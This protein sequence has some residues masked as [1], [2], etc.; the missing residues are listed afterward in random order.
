MRY[1]GAATFLVHINRLNRMTD[2]SPFRLGNATTLLAGKA[3]LFDSLQRALHSTNSIQT[4]QTGPSPLFIKEEAQQWLYCETSG[5]TGAAKTIKRSP[6]S[7]IRSFAENGDLF[8]LSDKDRYATLGHI[9]HS[10]TLYAL[11]E[12]FHHGADIAMMDSSSPKAQLLSLFEHQISILYATPTQLRLLAHAARAKNQA[13]F[14]AL[15]LLMI[16][17]GKLDAALLAEMKQLFPKAR[18]HEF[19]GSSE[20]SF[21]T[22]SDPTTPVGSVGRPYPGVTLHIRHPDQ[23]SQSFKPFETGEIWINS[24]YLFEGYTQGKSAYTYREGDF[25]TI[26]EMGYLDDKGYLYLKGRKSRMVTVADHNVFLQD[27]EQILLGH[28]RVE[29]CAVLALEDALRGSRIIAII[30]AKDHPDLLD[31]LRK[32]CSQSLTQHA[33]PKSFVRL[34]SLPKLPS[35]KADLQALQTWIETQE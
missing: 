24:P 34:D 20:T 10:L 27:V 5:S 4:C 28:K 30:E 33:I 16:G 14:P 12:A 23:P 21:L 25:L 18:L 13:L 29:D 3:D 31:E 26:G 8:S 9:G 6:R 35:G 2:R 7:W 11:L 22:L 17:G 32:T 1:S 19:Y 15:R